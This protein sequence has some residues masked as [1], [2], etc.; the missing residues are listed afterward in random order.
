MPLCIRNLA[1]VFTGEGFAQKQGRRPEAADCGFLRGPV[2]IVCGSNGRVAS[3]RRTS[4]RKAQ[5]D[6]CFDGTGLF[7]T[8]GFVDSHTHALFAGSRAPEFFQR[9]EGRSYVEISRRNYFLG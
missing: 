3:I 5:P 1:G 9:W 8:A 7:A 6:R 4:S 2:D